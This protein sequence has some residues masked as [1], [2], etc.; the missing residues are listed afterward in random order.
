[1]L[2]HKVQEIEIKEPVLC[3]FSVTDRPAAGKSL[4]EVVQD[5]YKKHW[6]SQKSLD[7]HSILTSDRESECHIFVFV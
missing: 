6:N 1:M 3:V 2:P 4:G 7:C 5:L